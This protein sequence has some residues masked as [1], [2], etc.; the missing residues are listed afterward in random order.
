M[1]EEV[2]LDNASAT[3]PSDNLANQM[4]PFMK[5][6]WKSPLAPY[7]FGKEPFTT[8]NRS[9][10]EISDFFQ[11]GEKDQFFLTPSGSVAIV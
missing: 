11:V 1:S 8:V 4:M 5:R 3:K 6:H 2:Y 9:L 7:Q 10:K